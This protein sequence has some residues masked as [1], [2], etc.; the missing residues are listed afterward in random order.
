[1]ERK[2]AV[3]LFRSMKVEDRDEGY[4]GL[5]LYR[6]QAG[7]RQ[8][9]AKIIYWDAEGQFTAETMGEVPLAILEELILEARGLVP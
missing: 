7:S 3:A 1:M 4:I 2:H 9:V 6:E 8:L 5:H